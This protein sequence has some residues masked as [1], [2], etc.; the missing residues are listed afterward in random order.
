MT[1]SE[2]IYRFNDGPHTCEC[3][4]LGYAAGAEEEREKVEEQLRSVYATLLNE[5]VFTGLATEEQW[6]DAIAPAFRRLGNV[7]RG[8]HPDSPTARVYKYP[9]KSTFTITPHPYG[10]K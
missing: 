4:D 9:D 7:V 3:F 8:Y 6:N 5:F 2:H 10:N 1:H